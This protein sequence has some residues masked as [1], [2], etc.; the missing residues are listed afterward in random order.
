MQIVKGFLLSWAVASVFIIVEK[1][2][3]PFSLVRQVNGISYRLCNIT[4]MLSDF[5]ALVAPFAK[6]QNYSDHSRDN[7]QHYHKLKECKTE[8]LL[9]YMLRHHYFALILRIIL[10]FSY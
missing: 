3:S 5:K 9:K 10:P 7:R 6:R 1:F 8:L 4:A 2:Y